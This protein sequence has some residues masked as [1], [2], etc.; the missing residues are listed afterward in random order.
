VNVAVRVTLRQVEHDA[1]YHQR[2]AAQHPDASAAISQSEGECD[3]NEWR[4][5]EN[6]AGSRGAE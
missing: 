4:K 6:R 2:C 3:A 5:R 1:G